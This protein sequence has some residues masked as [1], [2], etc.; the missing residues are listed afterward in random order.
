MS[1]DSESHRSSIAE[2][3]CASE[4]CMHRDLKS[5]RS[6][7]VK[8]RPTLT[9]AAFLSTIRHESAVNGIQFIA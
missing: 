3:S 6:K 8:N 2:S 7:T 9:L 1:D 5:Q 4:V